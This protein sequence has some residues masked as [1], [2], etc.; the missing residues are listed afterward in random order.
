MIDDAVSPHD[1]IDFHTASTAEERWEA[2]RSTL[3][4]AAR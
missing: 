1:E 2:V 3:G 4:L